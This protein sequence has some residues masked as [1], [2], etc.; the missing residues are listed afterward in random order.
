VLLH[1]A[2]HH[3]PEPRRALGELSRCL[4]PGGLLV[5]GYEPNRR[6]FAP[7]RRLADAL[8]LTEKHSRRLVPGRYS[9]AD[10]ETPGFYARELREWVTENGLRVEWM[11]PVW[12]VGAFAYHLPALSHVLLRRW[13]EVPSWLRR[14]ARR[15]DDALFAVVAPVRELC[16]AWSLGAVK[17]EVPD[18]RHEGT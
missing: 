17:K 8:R 15:A 16:F 6:V 7:L 18:A 11:E 9:L 1:A 12:L 4:G 14:F 10:D 3:L 2:L 13:F 5:L